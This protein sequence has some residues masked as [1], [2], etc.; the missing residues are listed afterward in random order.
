[1]NAA[2]PQGKINEWMNHTTWETTSLV[3]SSSNKESLP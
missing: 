1:M 2:V 3:T